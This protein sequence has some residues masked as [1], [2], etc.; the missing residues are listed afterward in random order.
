MGTYKNKFYAKHNFRNYIKVILERHGWS[1]TVKKESHIA[2]N[3]DTIIL[4]WL[5]CTPCSET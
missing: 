1:N 2:E 5:G 3:I 4:K